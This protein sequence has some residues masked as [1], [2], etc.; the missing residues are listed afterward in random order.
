MPVNSTSRAASLF[1]ASD[2][3]IE[4]A[5]HVVARLHAAG[6]ESYFVGGC[7]RDALLGRRL[8][9]V[10][11]ATAARPDDIEALFGEAVLGVGRAFGV[12]LVR[13]PRGVYEVATFRADG[14]Y[15][16]GRHPGTVQYADAAAD[17]RRRDFTI[18]ALFYDPRA[19][20]LLDFVEG[21]RD[22]DRRI[23]RA[24]GNP[25]A[26]FAEDK[27]RLL[28]AVRFAVTLGFSIDPATAAAMRLTASQLKVV[29]AERIGE[30]LTRMLVEASKPSLVFD[31]LN[32]YGMLDLLLPEVAA[33]RGVPQPPEFHPEGDVWI[34]TMMMLDAMPPPPR[35]PT[36]AYAVLLHDVGKPRTTVGT[37]DAEGKSAVRSPN[38]ASV[39]AAMASA[40]LGRLKQP[41]ARREAVEALVRRHMT[42]AELPNMRPSTLRRFM[43]V[44]T[45]PLDLELHRLDVACSSGD[46][47]M[48]QFVEQRLK[49]LAS[50]PVLP[51]P[52]VRGRDL[53][54]MGLPEGPRIGHW[55]QKAYNWQLEGRYPDREALRE[56]LRQ[57]LRRHGEI[58]G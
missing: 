30:E 40:I 38:H 26:R 52:W 51:D 21:R 3:R 12:M 2:A 48:L 29:S 18:N 13:Q 1:D 16:D 15:E 28:R 55:L 23:V 32:R 45:F 34:H 20:R 37:M 57:T 11:I 19:D 46:T 39:G 33:L 50:E 31:L 22:L 54:A 56:S 43:G 41:A 42:F 49:E 7:V 5:R 44:P 36:L 35:D 53:L 8:K 9:D 6:F 47:R 25:S 58:D 24:I 27:L 10:D 14:E 17:A 4:G